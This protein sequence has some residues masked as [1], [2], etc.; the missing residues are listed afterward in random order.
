MDRNDALA[1][2]GFMPSAEVQHFGVILK[3]LRVGRRLS[4]R[5]LADASGISK[6][7]IQR[8]EASPEII[9]RPT[10]CAELFD[11]LDRHSA[12]LEPDR[13]D[14][15]SLTG[16]DKIQASVQ[17]V[18]ERFHGASLTNDLVARNLSAPIQVS[19]DHRE[20]VAHAFLQRLIE[21]KGAANVLTALEAMAAAWSIDLPP[22]PAANDLPLRE[23]WALVRSDEITDNGYRVRGLSQTSTRGDQPAP[24]A[25]ATKKRRT[26]S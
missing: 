10:T 20:D 19:E 11:A 14:Y 15:L 4:Q 25:H 16:L 9:P 8:T 18:V 1:P 7:T 22:R 24:T 2:N 3:R 5:E 17:A 13:S 21:E 23:R 26:A 6:G 12:I